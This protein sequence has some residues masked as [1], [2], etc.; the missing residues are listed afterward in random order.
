MSELYNCYDYILD[1]DDEFACDL[2]EVASEVSKTTQ[3]PYQSMFTE[4]DSAHSEQ[5]L[6]NLN[7]SP[8]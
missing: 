7:I 8:V 4:S 5:T 6:G 1:D 3:P 2:G